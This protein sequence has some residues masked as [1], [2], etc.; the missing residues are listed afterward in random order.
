VCG[1]CGVCGV[2][3]WCGVRCVWCVCVCDVCVVCVW[4]VCMCGVCV[5]VC[6]CKFSS[7]KRIRNS[8]SHVD[9]MHPSMFAKG[10]T[11]NHMN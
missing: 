7:T 2:C 10:K 5:C 4:C 11:L 1:V 8:A 3:V 9:E 6:V